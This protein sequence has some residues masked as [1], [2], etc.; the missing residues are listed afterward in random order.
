MTGLRRALRRPAAAVGLALAATLAITGLLVS[1]QPASAG[2]DLQARGR[3]LYLTGCV[4][5]HGTHGEGVV[6]PDGRRRGPSLQQS[7][8]AGAYYYLSTGRMPLGSSSDQPRRKKRAYEGTDLQ[9]LVAYV[10]SLGTGPA[11]PL[12]DVR[13]GDLARGGEIYRA[14]CQACHSASGSGGVLSYGRA[15]PS[16]HKAEPREIAAA[17]RTGPGQMPVF[18][19]RQIGGRDLDSVV[20]YV[21]YLRNPRDPGG[22]PIGRIGPIPEGFVAWSVGMVALLGMVAWIGTRSPIRRRAP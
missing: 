22:L 7:G 13:A 3:Q 15:A 1:R 8:E 2:G 10:A 18:A 5:C 14:N 6:G 17:M 20:R 19:P 4:S 12:V 16:L 9:A 21:R 11:A